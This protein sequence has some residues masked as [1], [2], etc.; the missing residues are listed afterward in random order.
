MRIVVCVKQ[1]LDPRGMTVNRKA[2]KVVVNRE[3][4]VLDPA[5]KAA[6]QVAA[7][8]KTALAASNGSS[9]PE[10]VTI[11]LGPERVDDAL[12]EAMA[13]G[14]D[15]AIHLKDAAFDQADGLVVANALAAA[16]GKIG[17]ADLILLGACALDTGSGEL[18]PRLAEALDAPPLTNV[19]W[20]EVRDGAVGV[21]RQA[22]DEFVRLRASLP[23][24]ASIVPEAFEASHADGWRLMDAYKKWTVEVWSANDLEL[25]EDDLR[26]MAVKKEDAFP[27]ERQ[28]GTRVKDAKELVA[29]LKRER[30]I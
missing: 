15:R 11:S 25:S 3:E 20:L 6:L 28:P 23:A 5:S 22:G 9:P 14:A 4:Y 26:P 16:I 13:F 18:A 12:R 2:E 7:A 21:V 10:I 17:A 8:V 29:M 1:I 24:V 30:V 27:P 19:V